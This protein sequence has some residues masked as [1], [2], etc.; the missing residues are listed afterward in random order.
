VP[1]RL[2]TVGTRR[3]VLGAAESGFDN[4]ERGPLLLRVITPRF[5]APC[6]VTFGEG[7]DQYGY[8]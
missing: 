3:P 2:R 6:S 7:S 5:R 8:T 1:A 4:V